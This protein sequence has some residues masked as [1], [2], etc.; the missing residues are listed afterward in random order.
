MA[1]II[2]PTPPST[3]TDLSRT[4][5]YWFLAL[6]GLIYA[7]GF[8][9]V[10]SFLETHGLRD[11]GSDLWKIRYI[12][13]GVF[14]LMV[15]AIT[16]AVPYFLKHLMS[17]RGIASHLLPTI[18][19]YI[20]LELGLFSSAMFA[21]HL[22][23]HENSAV[24]IWAC[25]LLWSAILGLF[26]AAWIERLGK[27][28]LDEDVELRA[29]IKR[30]LDRIPIWGSAIVAAIERFA[31]S[32]GPDRLCR[33]GPR[34]RW[35]TVLATLYFLW[36]I[37]GANREVVE[38]LVYRL[39]ASVMLL[40][41]T[42]I[43]GW[44][45]WRAFSIG[46]KRVPESQRRSMWLLIGCLVI[47]TYYFA[48]IAFSR[49]VFPFIPAVRG[50]GDYSAAPTVRVYLKEQAQRETLG[51][52]LDT[53]S[54]QVARTKPIIFLEETATTLFVASP[55]DAGGPCQWRLDADKKPPVL[56][57]NRDAIANVQYLS[58]ASAYLD[59]SRVVSG[60]NTIESAASFEVTFRDVKDYLTENG[61]PPTA[62]GS[63]ANQEN[64]QIFTARGKSGTGIMVALTMD[65]DTQTSLRVAVTKQDRYWY[66][67]YWS[68]P[69]I[70]EGRTDVEAHGL[71]AFLN[72][73]HKHIQP[74]VR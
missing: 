48:L 12:R 38:M 20:A 65:N 47:P 49:A 72:S 21:R 45:P 51:P 29:K 66:A 46:P 53:T 42:L 26:V 16:N 39:P 32:M 22:G 1:E 4:I 8:L 73:R 10:S 40:S 54:R 23:S 14:C 9:I 55:D 18:V 71:E 15:T 31:R 52:Y 44:L 67:N 63:S 59:C 13:I 70:D 60:G 24:F 69:V 74:S 61:N 30:I 34:I 6:V 2:V 7:S 37:A 43:L 5:P 58:P 56:S 62:P 35:V 50:G 41:F 25:G 68:T 27:G 36:N 28:I 3:G 11:A 17:T 64:G 33:F 57:I 19:I